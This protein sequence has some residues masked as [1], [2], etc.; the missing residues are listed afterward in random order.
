MN[1][2]LKRN[3]F[4]KAVK[5]CEYNEVLESPEELSRDL[6]NYLK[7][8]FERVDGR[9]PLFDENGDWISAETIEACQKGGWA[10]PVFEKTILKNLKIL[11]LTKKGRKIIMAKATF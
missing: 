8:G 10:E 7:T 11:R 9:L 2:V 3:N 4:E 6:L 5:D 1:Y